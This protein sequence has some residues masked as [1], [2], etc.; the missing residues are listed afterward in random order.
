[1]QADNLFPGYDPAE[2]YAFVE[3]NEGQL[4]VRMIWTFLVFI[5]VL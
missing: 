4:L 2:R 3:V 1:V 5:I